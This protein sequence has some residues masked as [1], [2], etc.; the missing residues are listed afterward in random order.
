MTNELST[1]II[2]ITIFILQAITLIAVMFP[3]GLNDTESYLRDVCITQE[4]LTSSITEL[5][6]VTQPTSTFQYADSCEPR[7]IIKEDWI[8]IYDSEIKLDNIN[9]SYW[10]VFTNSKSM[11]PTF[12]QYSNA[13]YI[14][15][16]T[17]ND[18]QPCDIISYVDPVGDDITHRVISTGY[19]EV[20]W[21]A[22][23]K[24]DNNVISEGKVRFDQI[25]GLL[26]GVLY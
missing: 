9:I 22:E 26:V 15:P 16:Q 17:P 13:I 1:K 12:G 21:Y 11:L 6:N 4:N 20:G 25:D 24:G 3:M 18:I 8:H 19:D 2:F 7:D 10:A 23:M 5:K 14:D